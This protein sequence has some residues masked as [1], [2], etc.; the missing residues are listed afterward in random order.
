[1]NAQTKLELTENLEDYLFDI[2][3]ILKKAPVVRIKDIAKKRGVKLSSTVVAVKSLAEKGLVN[4]QKYEYIT[5]TEKGLEIA[6]R[7]ENRKKILYKF[8]TE[9]LNVSEQSA[10]RDVHKMEHDLSEETINKIIEFTEKSQ[11]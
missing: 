2:F 6:Q 3:E 10:I 5:L 8:L 11:Q 7:I 4:Y 9:I 1:M